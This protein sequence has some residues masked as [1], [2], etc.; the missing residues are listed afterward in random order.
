LTE[1][2][3]DYVLSMCRWNIPADAFAATVSAICAGL[4]VPDVAVV[5]VFGSFALVIA[6]IAAAAADM[7]ATLIGSYSSGNCSAN[8]SVY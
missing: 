7:G 4:V 1:Y 3:T 6:A 5:V 2:V 8:A